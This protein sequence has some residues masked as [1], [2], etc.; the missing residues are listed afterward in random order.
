M[1]YELTSAER[2]INEAKGFIWAG[3]IPDGATR[4]L[5]LGKSARALFHFL[6]PGSEQGVRG[7]HAALLGQHLAN[8]LESLDS[9]NT[10]ESDRLKNQLAGVNMYLS[11]FGMP[12]VM[13]AMAESQPAEAVLN[14]ASTVP[15]GN[16]QE[17]RQLV[18][19]V[20]SLG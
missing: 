14:H 11:R 10:Y 17:E 6:D 4:S 13:Q 8:Q 9:S 5:I 1:A 3:D 18:D 16:G 15:G 12:A 2:P 20:Q 7:F 19:S